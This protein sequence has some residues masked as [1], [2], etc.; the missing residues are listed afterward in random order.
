MPRERG[1]WQVFGTEELNLNSRTTAE[2]TQEANENRPQV[3]LEGGHWG[4]EPIKFPGGER[5]QWSPNKWG[6]TL[7]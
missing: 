5:A 3:S 7:S 4:R 2:P 6:L 1:E